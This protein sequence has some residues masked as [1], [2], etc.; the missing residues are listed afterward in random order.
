MSLLSFLQIDR[1]GSV[2]VSR[3]GARPHVTAGAGGFVDITARAKKIV[4]SG[5]FTAGAARNR[6]GALEILTEGKVK[7]LV[8]AVEQ[9]SFPV[10]ARW[11]R[12]R[13]SSTSRS[14]A[15]CASSARA[16]R[17]SSWRRASISSATCSHRPASS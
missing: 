9:V 16:S 14:D 3:L 2:N 11:L 8:E 6:A 10:R 12:A 4:F 7:K 5:Y 17:S 1:Q 13:R 15:S